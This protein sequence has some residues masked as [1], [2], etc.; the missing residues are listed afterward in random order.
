MAKKQ[1]E[2]SL[3]PLA[4]EVRVRAPE[5]TVERADATTELSKRGRG[6]PLKDKKKLDT[7]SVLRNQ[8]RVI[9][10]D[11]ANKEATEVP[12]VLADQRAMQCS[13][14]ARNKTLTLLS[15]H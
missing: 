11:K 10:G 5:I 9:I 7:P 8:R 2:K 3:Q 13:D 15:S 4:G 12:D 1:A 6:R 14:W